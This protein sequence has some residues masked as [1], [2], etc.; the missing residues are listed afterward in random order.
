[1]K[2]KMINYKNYSLVLMMS[3]SIL[4]SLFFLTSCSTENVKDGA[5]KPCKFP[6]LEGL[7]WLQ[8]NQNPDGSWG[9]KKD[10]AYLLSFCLLAYSE[11]GKTPSSEEFGDTVLKALKKAVEISEKQKTP[12]PL[13]AMAIAQYYG[14][15]KIP[16][17]ETAMQKD[18]KKILSGQNPDGSF[19]YDK[20]NDILNIGRQNASYQ[21]LN[22]LTL[23]R[24]YAAGCFESDKAKED[25]IVEAINQGLKYSL[26]KYYVR[27]Q[28]AFRMLWD[29][30]KTSILATAISAYSLPYADTRYGRTKE[31]DSA[32]LKSLEEY[33]KEKSWEDSSSYPVL[34]SHFINR[35]IF[36]GYQGKGEVWKKWSRE[37]HTELR[38]SQK[39]DGSWD[40][41]IE[42]GISASPKEKKIYS[43]SLSIL[44]FEVYYMFSPDHGGRTY[45]PLNPDDKTSETEK[46]LIIK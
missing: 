42:E 18:I 35:A 41:E 17:L 36:F 13:L 30:T 26:E 27:E 39:D 14:F 22:M 15:T 7:R 28:N 45:C 20:D 8:L 44:M 33:V 12:N 32:S 34:T 10:D 1:M 4:A 3:F 21:C 23:L 43:T 31:E 16:F 38:E 29:D 19:M 25:E 40:R 37:F 9:D 6:V 2:G 46:G 5:S 24:A 11:H